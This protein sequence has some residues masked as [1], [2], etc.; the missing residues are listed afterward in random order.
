MSLHFAVEAAKPDWAGTLV[1]AAVWRL[2]LETLLL[3]ARL[4][5]S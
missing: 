1:G 4:Y 2:S 3:T 5:Y